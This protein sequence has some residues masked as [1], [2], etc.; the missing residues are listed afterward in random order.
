M[1][2]K[3]YFTLRCF[4]LSRVSQLLESVT[5]TIA[6]FPSWQHQWEAEVSL[7]WDPDC[8]RSLI[9]CEN[10]QVLQGNSLQD[11]AAFA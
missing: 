6:C 10:M 4:A 1:L 3:S 2:T 7:P 9:S 11:N 8:R 5:H